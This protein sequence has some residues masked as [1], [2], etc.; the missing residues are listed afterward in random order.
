[1]P[2]TDSPFKAWWRSSD[3]VGKLIAALAAVGVTFVV[4]W[5]KTERHEEKIAEL[6]K[7][8]VAVNVKMDSN[9]AA[10]NARIDL[11]R[12]VW[13][14]ALDREGKLKERISVLEARDKAR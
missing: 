2:E 14:E 13:L 11:M 12:Q 8:M 9:A 10:A 3:V 1:M 6:Q 4:I 7:D 5:A